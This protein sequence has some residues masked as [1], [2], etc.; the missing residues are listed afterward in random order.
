MA[1]IMR[2]KFLLQP[3]IHQQNSQH[4]CYSNFITQSR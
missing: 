3:T 1:R 4:D 2:Y